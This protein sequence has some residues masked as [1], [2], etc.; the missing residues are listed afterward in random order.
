MEWDTSWPFLQDSLW[1]SQQGL[2]FPREHVDLD[3]LERAMA[4][5]AMQY[6]RG[7]LVR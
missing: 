2:R 5:E 3:N 4:S 6:L 1:N 7:G